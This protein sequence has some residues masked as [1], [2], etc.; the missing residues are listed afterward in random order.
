MMTPFGRGERGL[1]ATWWWT[2]DRLLLFG[3]AALAL[4]GVVL[5][6]AASP[7]V[8]ERLGLPGLH[9]VQR[10]GL[11]LVLGAGL[12]LGA[13]LL[14]P[15]GV[16]RLAVGAF[17][18]G[19][20]LVAATLLVGPEIKGARRW[21][22]LGGLVVQPSEFVKPA[23]AVV[24]A[25]LLARRSGLAGV[26]PAL[27]PAGLFLGLLLLQP[28]IGMAAVVA[29]VAI[30]Q[31]F[32]AGLSWLWIGG[33]GALALALGLLAY[34]RL[35]HVAERIDGFIDPDAGNP[36]QID[37]ALDAFSGAG[38]AGRGP[39]EGVAKFF[40]P[41]AH[42]DFIFAAA[43]EE[44]GFLAGLLLVGLFAFLL[45]RG[46][47]RAY[48]HAGDGFALLAAAGLLTQFGLQAVINMGVNLR[49]LP[50]KGMTLPFISYGGSS[51]LAMALGM[52]MVLAL[53]RRRVGRGEAVG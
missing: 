25:W 46:L 32:L 47:S 35:P 7:P 10:H 1:L 8:A 45:L 20:V 13:S 14:S 31:L 49:L 18:L 6:F 30:V 48:S 3:T 33:F 29:A 4:I 28:D 5:V 38:W 42:S 41:D 16:R 23:L 27:L 19:V 52:G 43:S 26:R 36:Y 22:P 44:F 37:R 50:T 2:V 34:W 51:L 11:F 21:L 40:L 24:T 39:G 17:A 53:T 9:F 12:L 15:E